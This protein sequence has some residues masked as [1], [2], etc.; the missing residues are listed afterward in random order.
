MAGLA[1]LAALLAARCCLGFPARGPPELL[2]GYIHGPMR[3]QLSTV[4]C[5]DHSSATFVHLLSG[6]RERNKQRRW[7]RSQDRQRKEQSKIQGQEEKAGRQTGTNGGRSGKWRINK[8]VPCLPACLR[9]QRCGSLCAVP[10]TKA[11]A[12]ECCATVLQLL[13]CCM[14]QAL[15]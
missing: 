9:F 5:A 15:L 7:H 1:G 11:G 3:V 10:G 12:V 2:L 6:L 13:L 4:Q 8:C 14:L